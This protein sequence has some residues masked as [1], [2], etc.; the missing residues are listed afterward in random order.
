[1][2]DNTTA[3]PSRTHRWMLVR[4]IRARPRLM[5]SLLVGVM[6]YFLLPAALAERTITRLIIGW[7]A[8]A[9]LY[10]ALAMRMMFKLGHQ[11]IHWRARLQDEGKFV[12][13]LLVIAAVLVSLGAI[14]AQLAVAKDMAGNERYAHIA[15]AVLTI[16]SS[17]SFTHVMFAQHYAHDYYVAL[18][19]HQPPGLDFPGET[20]PDYG[21]FL[22]FSCIIGTSGQTA[23]IGFSSRSM[24]RIGLVHSVLAFFFNT[25]LVALT[26]NIASSFV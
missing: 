6:V 8:G 5:I 16:V 12:V 13:L 9:W 17:W 14:F 2:N 1:M 21:D 23:D 24:R 11:N 7:N 18:A 19:N 25:T 3:T 26:I 10:L 15:L 20:T 4:Q 22:Y